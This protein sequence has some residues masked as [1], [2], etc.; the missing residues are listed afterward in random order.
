[1]EDGSELGRVFFAPMHSSVM[2][3]LETDYGSN[4]N[5]M[6]KSVIKRYNFEL[7]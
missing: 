2:F 4:L 7:N 6:A 3:E 1:M 5:R